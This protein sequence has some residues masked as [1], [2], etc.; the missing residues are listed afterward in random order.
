MSW[1]DRLLPASFRGA[2]FFVATDTRQG[3]RR[4]AVHEYP[5][6]DIP[7]AE[8]LGRKARTYAI[9]AVLV[10]PNY[11]RDLAVLLAALEASGSGLLTH[12]TYGLVAVCVQGFSSAL[13]SAEGGVARVQLDLVEAGTNTHPLAL[14]DSLAGVAAAVDQVMT[15]IQAVLDPALAYVEQALAYAALAQ[16]YLLLGYRIVGM[17]SLV[18]EAGRALLGQFLAPLADLGSTL[19]MSD[20]NR[21]AHVAGLGSAVRELDTRAGSAALVGATITAELTALRTRAAAPWPAWQALSTLTAWGADLPVVPTST[22][23]R[24]VQAH[25]QAVVVAAVRDGALAQ[26]LLA[27]LSGVADAADG[28]AVAALEAGIPVAGPE[29]GAL[30]AQLTGLIDARQAVA[31]DPLY[32]AWAAVRVAVAQDLAARVLVAPR[33]TT[34][35]PARTLPALVL[36]YQC[37]GDATRDAEIIRRN[38][39]AH[40]GFVPG[41]QALEVR[42]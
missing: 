33:L 1:R 2:R 13:S 7:Y 21:A 35:V 24:L 27:A 17:P 15:T 37:H 39:I 6:R 18:V 4:L 20:A 34:V 41:G 23:A 40:P 28:A 9:E 10:G 42:T 36:A 3:G 32:A 16:G 19:G 38:G 22:A 5:L 26:G 8:D 31:S 14:P 25:N 11:D 12:P 30:C 29:L